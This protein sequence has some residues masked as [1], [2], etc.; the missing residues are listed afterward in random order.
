MPKVEII[1]P[2]YLRKFRP[3]NVLSLV[4]RLSFQGPYPEILGR[5]SLPIV[6]YCF[7]EISPPVIRQDA[8]RAAAAS[9]ANP[10]R[11][12]DVLC[13]LIPLAVVV[14]SGLAFAPVLQNT[15]G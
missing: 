8:L 9:A 12:S 3:S 7:N 1:P 10:P 2:Q 11:G 13:R 14:I 5:E 4:A 6:R 15:C